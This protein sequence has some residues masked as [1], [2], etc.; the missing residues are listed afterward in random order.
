MVVGDDGIDG[1][2]ELDAG[3]LGAGEEPADVDVV[4]GVAGD[5]AEGGAEAAD[6]AGLLAVRDGVVADDVVAD[7]LP[8]PGDRMRMGALD[9]LDVALGGVGRGVVVLVAVFAEGDAGADGVADDVVLDDP[10]L[11]PVGADQADLLGGRRRPGRGGVAQ[12][13]AAHGDVVAARLVRDR[14]RCGGR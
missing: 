14:T 2:V 7:V 4:D 1:G 10:A 9:G 13:E 8:G 12:G 5:G 11:A 6:D 3:H